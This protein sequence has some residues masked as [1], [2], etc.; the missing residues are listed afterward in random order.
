MEKIE[1]IRGTEDIFGQYAE[2]FCA[3]KKRCINFAKLYGYRYIETP[4]MENANL[5]IRSVG[6]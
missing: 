5:F 3:I 6:A 4:I 1:K 2:E